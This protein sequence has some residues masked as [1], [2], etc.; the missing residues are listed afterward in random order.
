MCVGQGPYYGQ[1]IHFLNYH[2]QVVSKPPPLPSPICDDSAPNTQ[3]H[4]SA[5]KRYI[6]EARRV[7]SVLEKEFVDNDKEWLVGGRASYADVSF[8]VWN[9][10]LDLQFTQLA[11]WKKEFPRVAE[12]DRKLNER[13]VV[14]AC[15][16]RWIAAIKAA[17]KA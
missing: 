6:D 5:I 1:A 7:L 11:D 17:G 4:E 9:K 3:Q 12:W 14:A 13:P 10:V 8:V 15:V 16:V 2:S